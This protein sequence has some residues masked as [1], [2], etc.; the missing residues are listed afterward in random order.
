MDVFMTCPMKWYYQ[1]I[2]QRKPRRIP[3]FAFGKLCHNMLEGRLKKQI[4]NGNS[5]DLPYTKTDEE[6]TEILRKAV[7]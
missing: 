4:Y 7:T 6:L 5:E 3:A 2:L 1:Y